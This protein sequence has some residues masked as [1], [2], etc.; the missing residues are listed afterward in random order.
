MVISITK[1]YHEFIFVIPET[2]S[3]ISHSFGNCLLGVDYV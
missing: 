2:F 1:I 3:H